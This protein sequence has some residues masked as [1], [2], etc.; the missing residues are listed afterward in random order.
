MQTRMLQVAVMAVLAVFGLVFAAHGQDEIAG[1]LYV[2]SST[3][4]DTVL[5]TRAK[6][7]AWKQSQSTAGMPVL[8]PWHITAP[9]KAAAFTDT[10]FPE[11]GVN[12]D[13]KS[14]EGE[15][16][17]TKCDPDLWADGRVLDLRS[18]GNSNATY[19]YRTITS[20]KAQTAAAG[21]G[22]DDGVEVWLNGAKVHSHEVARTVNPNEDR[23][24]LALNAGENAFLMKIYN[25]NG[26]HGFYFSLSSDPSFAIW[27]RIA[28]DFPTEFA[29]IK[30]DMEHCSYVGLF[31]G[32]DI[33]GE[34][35]RAISSVLRSTDQLQQPLQSE[36]DALVAS[37]VSA[38]DPRWLNLYVKACKIRE[39]VAA[40]KPVDL[41][42]M[43]RAIESLAHEFPDKY[44]DGESFLKRLD[45][46]EKGM[47]ALL[48]TMAADPDL[49]RKTVEELKA[50]QKEAL[51]ANPLLDFDQ[52]LVVKRAEN[53][54]GLPQNW[55]GNCAISQ[56]GYEN[57]IN[58]FSPVRPEGELKPFFKPENGLFVGDVDLNFNADKML[59]SMP[60]SNGRWQI[61][62][63]N[64]DGSG[65]RQVTPGQEPDVDNYD[66]CYLPDGRITFAS[67]RC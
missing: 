27:S 38:D 53:N 47:P 66:A 20:E 59:F 23:V 37:A 40:L 31:N 63:I 48:T 67:T 61:W 16:L 26:G 34:T 4:Q 62:E 10:F 46:Y 51:L 32:A 42:A 44:K 28:G 11:Q 52:L 39:T 64:A 36:L 25:V 13:A 41:A 49:A 65:L 43:R 14:P 21:I 8:G 19:L 6:Y 50:F 15:A 22:S 58:V 29:W 17:W 7:S 24:A 54:L 33:L 60:G 3:W 18:D 1:Q 35:K 57:E 12:L 2:K 45:A 30:R 55:Q 56:G 5:Q 9:L